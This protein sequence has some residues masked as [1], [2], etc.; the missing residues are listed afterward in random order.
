MRLGNPIW[1]W[2]LIPITAMLLAIIMPVFLRIREIAQ[3]VIFKDKLNDISIALIAYANDNDGNFP[4]SKKW[5]ELLIQ[6][7]DFMNDF[8]C[9]LGEKDSSSY[10]VNENL[11]KLKEAAVV[12]AEMVSLFDA[13]LGIN[14]AGGADD[15]ILKHNMQGQFG[16]NI[17]FA[18]GTVKFV[19][20]DRIENLKWV[21]TEE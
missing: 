5:C 13:D 6:E 16:C 17:A 12:P 2:L 1:A 7:T 15:V 21:V 9:P 20:E 8:H 19:T 3:R 4:I 18:D 11:Y 14:G 10:A